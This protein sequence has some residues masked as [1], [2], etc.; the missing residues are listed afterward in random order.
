MTDYMTKD[1]ERK[2]LA[3]LQKM[4]ENSTYVRTAFEGA[5]RIAEANIHDDA[6]YTCQYWVDEAL[7]KGSELQST[8]EH[9]QQLKEKLK[10]TDVSI[11]RVLDQRHEAQNELKKFQR[12]LEEVKQQLVEVKEQAALLQYQQ[13]QEII[14]LKALLYDLV[15]GAVSVTIT[16]KSQ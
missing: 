3:K 8:K 4:L 6:A 11:N 16:N 13:A 2:L 5:W 1:E 14:E 7:R 12:E 15:T 10:S 9:V